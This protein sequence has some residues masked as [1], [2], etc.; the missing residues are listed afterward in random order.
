MSP[1][2]CLLYSHTQVRSALHCPIAFSHRCLYQPPSTVL[3]FLQCFPVSFF[4]FLFFYRISICWLFCSLLQYRPLSLQPFTI[5]S[6]HVP[7]LTPTE[8]EGLFCQNAA[9][10]NA[11]V[12]NV[13]AEC[14]GGKRKTAR[15]TDYRIV[16]FIFS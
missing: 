15:V 16:K 13:A 11:R 9:I 8:K 12:E 4:I 3:C 10:E 2:L 7:L 1:M 6:Y 14:R 5:N